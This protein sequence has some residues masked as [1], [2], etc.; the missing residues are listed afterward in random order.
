MNKEQAIEQFNKP[1]T[2]LDLENDWDVISET[3]SK[4]VIKRKADGL[5]IGLGKITGH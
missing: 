5:I 1:I 4:M 2:K 3:D